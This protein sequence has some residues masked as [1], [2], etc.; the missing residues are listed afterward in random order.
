M[1]LVLDEH[2]SPTIAKELRRRD[3][4]VVAAA[5]V[6][7]RQQA[8]AA[9]MAW[10]VGESRALVTANCDDFRALHQAYLSRGDRH[11]GVVFVPRRFS[12]AEAGFGRLIAA[13][14]RLL[15]E[16]PQDDALEGVETWLED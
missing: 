13:L 8:D 2:L 11:V 14:E 1:K 4:D 3:H 9:V 10:A 15:M 5:E 7:L 6:G 12:L 16:H